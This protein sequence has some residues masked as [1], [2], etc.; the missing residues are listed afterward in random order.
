MRDH[1]LEFVSGLR[2][3][4]RGT[5]A[6]GCGE[7]LD[8]LWGEPKIQL[9]GPR[10]SLPIDAIDEIVARLAVA[11]WARRGPVLIALPDDADSGPA[12]ALATLLLCFW[13][14]SREASPSYARPVLYLGTTVGIRDDLSKVTVRGL[15]L[16]LSDTLGH[17]DLTRAG[18]TLARGHRVEH[19]DGLP[20]ITTAYAPADVAG[21]VR[22]SSPPFIAAD[23][24]NHTEVPW[25]HA[26][27]DVARES[28][29][30]LVMWARD[31]LAIDQS[32]R[33]A[34][35]VSLPGISRQREGGPAFRSTA[36]QPLVMSGPIAEDIA[37]AMGRATV[38]LAEASKWAAV[39]GAT[40]SSVLVSDAVRLHRLRLRVLEL[41]PCPVDLYDAGVSAHWGM[42]STRDIRE[43]CTRFRAACEVTYPDLTRALQVAAAY[44][45][46]V[47]RLLR[48]ANPLWDAACS[49]AVGTRELG[50]HVIFGTGARKDLFL[51]ALLVAYGISESDLMSIGVRAT[52]LSD[53]GC[54]ATGSEGDSPPV[55]S[56]VVGQIGRVDEKRLAS[57]AK[58]ESVDIAL[59]SHQLRPLQ[60]RVSAWA[61]SR[62]FRPDL[63][64]LNLGAKLS[65]PSHQPPPRVRLLEPISLVADRVEPRP[66]E[67]EVQD[68]L[69]P[70]L[71]AELQRFYDLAGDIDE[72]GQEAATWSAEPASGTEEDASLVCATGYY[73]QFSGG[74]RATFA[75]DQEVMFV[76]RLGKRATTEIR[77]ARELRHGVEIVAIH[78]QRRQS[79]YDLLVS[80]LHANPAVALQ[81][82]LIREWQRE[83]SSAYELWRRSGGDL[84][85]LVG[86]LQAN[87]SAITST[88]AV[89][90]WLLGHTI[91][92]QDPRDI[93]RI[94]QIL[95]MPFASKHHARIAAA[96]SRLRGLHRG[97]SNRL[98]NWLEREIAAGP[99]VDDHLPLDR[100]LG[101]T[102]A[103]FASTL[104]YLTVELAEEREGPFL[105]ASLGYFQLGDE[106]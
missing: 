35:V 44:L 66:S 92:P 30:P 93:T 8:Q 21:L 58:L 52:A 64:G 90:F 85:Q 51:D 97:L 83:L 102:F 1:E 32:V 49:L 41:M 4:L 39:A 100:E 62:T 20:S 78:G 71:A 57:V 17:T 94:A 55:R 101:V 86:R 67:L 60:S 14:K 74:W 31:P 43:S 70:D 106:E 82:A 34:T 13:W 47:E 24:G 33:G 56:V 79:L 5:P 84:D 68:W 29:I 105:R 11:A 38:A 99:Q 23:L 53:R 19:S 91:A 89:R 3:V 9:L 36:I 18:A 42:T 87:G 10:G 81:L 88:L 54:A 25:A 37:A 50:L 72:E 28:H 75:P 48:Q 59:Y 22:R 12:L 98:S 96:A 95:D 77:P 73:V 7:I 63:L 69:N 45:D 65:D 2:E 40:R 80:R 27:I 104:L 26:L 103:D 6:I 61:T 15:G 76:R 46:E 16:R